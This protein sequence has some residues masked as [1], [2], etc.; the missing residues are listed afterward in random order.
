MIDLT[1]AELA[2][3]RRILAAH[4]PHREVRAFGSRVS[5]RATKHSDLDLLVMGSGRLPMHQRGE[6]RAAF[7]DSVLPM[8]VDVVDWWTLD[9]EMQATIAG[10][11]E[12][13]QAGER[14]A[15]RESGD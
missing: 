6:L 12:V 2:L 3:V 5:G 11:S 7:A 14:P 4:L 15:V 10:T 1:P 13:I 8:C 9:P